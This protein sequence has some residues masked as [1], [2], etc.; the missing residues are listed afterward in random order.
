MNRLLNLAGNVKISQR[1]FLSVC[2]FALP[3]AVLFL[4]AFAQIS[5]NVRFGQLEMAGLRFQRPLLRLVK[6]SGDYRLAVLLGDAPAAA[7]LRAEFDTRLEQL[8]TVYREHA[9]DLQFSR[10]A[11]QSEGLAELSL[12]AGTNHWRQLQRA[13]A[14]GNTKDAA[15]EYDALLSTL[16]GMTSRAGDTS[17]LTLDPEMDS[18]YLADVASIAG[19]QTLQ[20]IATASQTFGPLLRSGRFTPADRRRLAVIAAMLRESDVD[21]IVT[22]L[23]TALKEN[24]KAKRGASSTLKASIDMALPAYRA[25][26]DRLIG[27]LE[28]DSG[29]LPR[30]ED[31]AAAVRQASDLSLALCEKTSDELAAVLDSRI[32]TFYRE[33]WT[34]TAA[35]LG[36]L[37]IAFLIFTAVVR[38]IT[39]PLNATVT[40]INRV[41]AGDISGD[42]PAGYAT[43][44]DEIGSLARAI[45][46][47][48]LSLR[49]MISDVGGGVSILS[50]ASSRLL[51]SSSLMS[52]G[53]QHASAKAQSVAAAADQLSSNSLS[54]SA[55]VEQTTTNL[56]NVATATGQMTST[57]GEI[58]AKSENA[59][60]IAAEATLQVDRVTAQ[61]AHLGSAVDAIGKVTETISAISSQTN[62]LALNATI[63][64]ARAGAAGKGFAVVA[65]E[66]KALA[67]Q[68]AA[69]TDDI[70]ARILGV[71]SATTDGVSEVTK[72]ANVISSVSRTV[73]SIASAIE[74]QA[75]STRDI[76]RNVSEASIGVADANHRM[77]ESSQATRE[78]ARDIAEV[79]GAA[80]DLF[81]GSGQVRDHAAALANAT[82]S[83]TAAMSR[84]HL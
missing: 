8:S 68:T 52:A 33:R 19:A 32:N 22:D 29:A 4:F 42:L 12:E 38:G 58:A 45:E 70:K 41:A 34:M 40:H 71:Q 79:E 59:R 3:L 75:S 82:D 55:G 61:I 65:N 13:D 51:E 46:A 27:L 9:Q 35:T 66:I 20:R 49:G 30:Q 54:V 16:R 21:R 17:N 63:E 74:D 80:R 81:N 11:L 77:A 28:R 14:A 73:N 60:S 56:S 6:A 24:Q 31:F 18:Y 43:R 64:A 7:R 48:S 1:I 62:L 83:L 53:A 47:M 76:S 37:A 23:Q 25:S 5:D 50:L 36:V 57:I 67:Q 15:T 44:G 78:I 72:I 84:F 2:L 26:L 39:N 10:A 69:A